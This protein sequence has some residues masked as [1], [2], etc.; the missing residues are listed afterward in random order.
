MPSPCVILDRD[1][2]INHDSD[3]YIRSLGEWQPIAGSIEA[4]G[5]LSRAGYKVYVAT[6][7][8]GLA[9][10]LLETSVLEQM[11]AELHRLV[12]KEGG[13]VSDIIYCPHGPEDGCHCRKPS[14]GM[15]QTLAA[16]HG[17][18]LAGIPVIGDSL[19]DLQAAEAVAALPMLVETGKGERTLRLRPDL[20]YPTFPDLYAA[21]Q[22]IIFNAL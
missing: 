12:S 14:P 11:H 13:E 18:D 16:T 10:G 1:G 2:V 4:I 20:D 9:R 8:S 19:R 22:H 21:A 17:F 7:Q 5:M 6:N 15:Y 3:H